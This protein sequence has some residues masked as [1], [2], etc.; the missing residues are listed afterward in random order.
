MQQDGRRNNVW[1]ESQAE[2]RNQRIYHLKRENTS[3]NTNE[4]FECGIMVINYTHDCY[5]KYNFNKL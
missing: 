5:L 4:L 2:E 1:K 3:K